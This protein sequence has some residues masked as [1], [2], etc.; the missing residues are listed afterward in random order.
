[1]S[2]DEFMA[3]SD[4]VR[5]HRPPGPPMAWHGGRGRGFDGPPRGDFDRRGGEGRQRREWRDGPPGPPPGPDA[6]PPADEPER[7][8][9]DPI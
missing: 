3:L 2:K 7:G 6:P 1:L 8:Q 9:E 4:F 5:E